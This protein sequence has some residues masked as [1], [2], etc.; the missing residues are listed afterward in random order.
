MTRTLWQ[1][2]KEDLLAG[3][4]LFRLL[5]Y[6]IPFVLFLGVLGIREVLL[7]R[8]LRRISERVSPALDG[9]DARIG[10]KSDAS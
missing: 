8:S 1:F 6:I 3:L 5:Y 7:S 10:G 4:L 2:D 9:A